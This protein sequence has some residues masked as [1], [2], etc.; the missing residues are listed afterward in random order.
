[1]VVQQKRSI[2]SSTYFLVILLAVVLLVAASAMKGSLEESSPVSAEGVLQLENW[3]MQKDGRVS[4]AGEWSFYWDKLLTS[5]DLHSHEVLSAG[6]NVHVPQAWNHYNLGGL[7]PHHKGYATFRLRVELQTSSDVL[8]LKIPVLSTAYK[9]MANGKTIAAGGHVSAREESSVAA[10]LPQTVYFKPQSTSLDLIVQISNYTERDGGMVEALELG[11]ADQ[12]RMLRDQ[13]LAGTMFFLGSAIIISLYY[14]YTWIVYGFVPA[15]LYYSIL[16]MLAAIRMLVIDHMFILQLAPGLSVDWLTFLDALSLYGGIA[17]TILFVHQL[18]PN[19][20]NR[21]VMKVLAWAGILFNLSL[22]A[23]PLHLYPAIRVA[24]YIYVSVAGGHLLYMLMHAIR[25][26]REGSIA[27][28]AGL[29]LSVLA[30]VHDYML[31][32]NAA[33]LFNKP[34]LYYVIFLLIFLE[35]TDFSRRFLE[36]RLPARIRS[37]D[38]AYLAR[39]VPEETE[40]RSDS[41]AMEHAV[42]R[43]E[44]GSDTTLHILVVDEDCCSL[45]MIHDTLTDDRYKI[46]SVMNGAEALA[47]IDQARKLD[48]VLLNGSVLGM[49]GIELVRRIRARYSHAEL[50]IIMMSFKE[51]VTDMHEGFQAGV[52]DFLLK[53]FQA[54]ELHARIDLFLEMKQLAESAATSEIAMLQ[55]EIKPHFLYNTLNTALTLTLE[56]PQKAHDLLLRLSYYLRNSFQMKDTS[57]FI[58]LSEEIELVKSYLYIEK[59]RFGHR[60]DIEYDIDDSLDITV[61]PLIIQPI[62]ENA[63]KHGVTQKQEGGKVKLTAR[64]DRGYLMIIVED[65]G[66]GM[67][68]ERAETLLRSDARL[69]GMALMNIHQRL[70]LIYGQGLNIWS[71]PG[72]GTRVEIRIPEQET[73]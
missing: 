20:F 5:G 12:M 17:I 49:S 4:L 36:P 56:E 2:A 23:V 65:N 10:Y 51:G 53:P 1:M 33:M 32:R 50:P 26:G 30:L 62:M 27:R 41:A 24:F 8:A 13:E 3:S 43:T 34:I 66:A 44:Q 64:A 21:S 58:G 7:R 11:S 38:S 52:N 9:V 54:H 46:A 28:L 19:E 31:S 71:E 63:V 16:C 45:R 35:T 67:A 57:K 47:H 70:L 6:T 69:S 25:S 59:A 73:D 68:L 15:A 18:F 48:V 40:D 55:A 72:K 61:P 39:E 29:V 22:F 37:P 42:S 14:F 60:L